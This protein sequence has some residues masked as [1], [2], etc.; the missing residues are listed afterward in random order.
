[1]EVIVETEEKETIPTN[2]NNP[3][4]SNISKKTPKTKKSKKRT[5]SK[6]K[7]KEISIESQPFLKKKSISLRESLDNLN[8]K[9]EGKDKDKDSGWC[10]KTITKKKEVY[11]LLLFLNFISFL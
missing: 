5:T 8:Q 4:N 10:S 9:K 3:S 11:I 2:G 1:M 6:K 7:N